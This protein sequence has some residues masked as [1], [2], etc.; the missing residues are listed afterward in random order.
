MKKLI[1]AAAMLASVLG[2]D[3]SGNYLH[4]NRDSLWN[5]S[6]ASRSYCTFD[7]STVTN[8]MVFCHVYDATTKKR[9]SNKQE[10]TVL[11]VLE[12]NSYVVKIPYLHNGKPDSPLPLKPVVVKLLATTQHYKEGDVFTAWGQYEVR[13]TANGIVQSDYRPVYYAVQI[14][15]T[16]AHVFDEPF[17]DYGQTDR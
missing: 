11:S 13:G 7:A 12:N 16:N 1:I 17:I 9:I 4:F 8:G 14:N 2:C 10:L 15:T 6:L 3:E 5:L